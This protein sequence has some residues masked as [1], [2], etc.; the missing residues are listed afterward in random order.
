[1]QTAYYFPLPN[2]KNNTYGILPYLAPEV[3]RGASYTIAADI[4]NNV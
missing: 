3:L 4:Y 1:M 2:A